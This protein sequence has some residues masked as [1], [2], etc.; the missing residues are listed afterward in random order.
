MM[1]QEIFTVE[2]E[3]LICAFSVSIRAALIVELR[4]AMPHFEEPEMT[5]IAE[6]ALK[7]LDTITDEEF[8]ALA[9]F[10]AYEDD[11]DEQMED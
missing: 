3:N 8:S 5:E 2:E 1:Y 11:N 4:A 9:F 6:G 10:P 7:K